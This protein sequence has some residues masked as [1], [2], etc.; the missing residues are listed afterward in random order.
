MIKNH[1]ASNK[2]FSFLSSSAENISTIKIQK[3]DFG[4]QTDKSN[5]IYDIQENFAECFHETAP[6]IVSLEHSYAF[7]KVKD[8][9]VQTLSTIKNIVNVDGLPRSYNPACTNCGMLND[10]LLKANKTICEHESS[11][12]KLATDMQLKQI[13]FTFLK[14]LNSLTKYLT[15]ISSYNVLIE[16]FQFIENDMVEVPNNILTKIQMFMLTLKRLK[17]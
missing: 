17:D 4:S 14:E 2:S 8:A 1:K 7:F 9:A 11:N 16:S 6:D 15:G 10:C 3:I 12:E 5:D 13:D